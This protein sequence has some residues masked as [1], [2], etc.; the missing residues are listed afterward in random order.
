MR[1]ILFLFVIFGQDNVSSSY[2][3]KCSSVKRLHRRMGI[4]EYY[5]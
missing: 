3:K 2:I 1:G 4:E 5:G